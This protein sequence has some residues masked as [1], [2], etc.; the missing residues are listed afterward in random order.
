MEIS[1]QHDGPD[2]WPLVVDSISSASSLPRNWVV[3]LKVASF[4]AR[5]GLLGS[6]PH[7]GTV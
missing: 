3:G 2:G 4:K 6:S 1:L 5:L 7:P